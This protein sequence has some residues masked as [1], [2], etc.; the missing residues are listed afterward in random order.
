MIAAH[1]H[2]HTY[3]VS[4]FL[5][6]LHIKLELMRAHTVIFNMHT[7]HEDK[8]SK[9][10]LMDILSLGTLAGSPTPCYSV[11]VYVLTYGTQSHN[12]KESF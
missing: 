11:Y 4:H 1:I 2:T 8:P 12:Y 6:V 3:N 10:C 5:L 9:I 7:H